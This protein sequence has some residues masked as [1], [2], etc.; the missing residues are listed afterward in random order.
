MFSGG[1]NRCTQPRTKQS[2]ATRETQRSAHTSWILQKT[3]SDQWDRSWRILL[4][5]GKLTR[6]AEAAWKLIE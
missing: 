3:A 2:S 6:L 1:R 5:V 4:F